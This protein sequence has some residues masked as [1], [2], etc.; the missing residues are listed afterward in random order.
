MIAST[1]RGLG[2]RGG[3]AVHGGLNDKKNNDAK[4]DGGTT[5]EEPSDGA[6]KTNPRTNGG[7]C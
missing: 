1:R 7:A 4:E 6:T 5:D 2:E 3:I